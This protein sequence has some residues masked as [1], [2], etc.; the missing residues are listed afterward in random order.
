[1][2][3]FCKLASERLHWVNCYH[4][5]VAGFDFDSTYEKCVAKFDIEEKYRGG[6]CFEGK[7]TSLLERPLCLLKIFKR[8]GR[9]SRGAIFSS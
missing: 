2:V 4:I 1:M 7:W 9:L 6:V 5:V 8:S 3:Y